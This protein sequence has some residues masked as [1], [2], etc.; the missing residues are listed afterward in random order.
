MQEDDNF[1]VFDD[2]SAN[3]DSPQET[4]KKGAGRVRDTARNAARTARDAVGDFANDLQSDLSGNM[5]EKGRLGFA[6]FLYVVFG[7]GFFIFE[8]STA[9]L[10]VLGFV[11]LF[12][13]DRHV[14]RMLVNVLAL[15]LTIKIGW[16]VFASLW[17]FTV[18]LLEKVLFF[19]P[20]S[21]FK[22]LS[23]VRSIIGYAYDFIFVL[24]GLKG[25]SKARKGEYIKVKYVDSL[26]D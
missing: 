19:A 21:I 22:F 20:S 6:M 5:A 25:M 17:A 12:E 9:I 18:M 11:A 2:G 14:V 15:Y 3:V 1:E 10:L 13:R 4:I 23:T 16:S 8:S 24:I 26:F 7:Y